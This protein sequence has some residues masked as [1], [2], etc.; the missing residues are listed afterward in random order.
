MGKRL[1]PSGPVFSPGN[2]VPDGENFK[3]WGTEE[4]ILASKR[5]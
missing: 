4:A 3:R 1:S 5:I 2:P